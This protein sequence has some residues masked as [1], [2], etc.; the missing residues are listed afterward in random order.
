[1]RTI[2]GLRMDLMGGNT[3]VSSEVS[4]YGCAELRNSVKSKLMSLNRECGSA[5]R[6]IEF[7]APLYES[8]GE[9]PVMNGEN[10]DSSSLIIL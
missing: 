5:V 4:L 7:D 10:P 8:V 6:Y 3:V 2:Y 1:M 9:V